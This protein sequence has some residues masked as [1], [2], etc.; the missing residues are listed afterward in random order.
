MYNYG[1][2][3]PRFLDTYEVEMLL[4]VVADNRERQQRTTAQQRAVTI[5]EV[6]PGVT[7]ID[8]QTDPIAIETLLEDDDGL[9]RLAQA[10][11][12]IFASDEALAA[13]REMGG[14]DPPPD[15]DP[16]QMA[17]LLGQLGLA[18]EE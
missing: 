16:A 9:A 17:A 2:S 13:Q 4:D 11:P 12:G 10:F 6:A 5:R 15:V 18:D 3:D 7:T 8:A 14:G 1:P